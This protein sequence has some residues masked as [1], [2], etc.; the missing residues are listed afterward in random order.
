MIVE[1]WL[2]WKVASQFERLRLSSQIFVKLWMCFATVV[3]H[4]EERGTA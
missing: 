1:L 3:C 4:G 2:F